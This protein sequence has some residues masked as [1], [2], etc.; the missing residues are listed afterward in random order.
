CWTPSDPPNDSPH[1][2]VL[3]LSFASRCFTAPTHVHCTK[4]CEPFEVAG[5]HFP[6][7]R[8][9]LSRRSPTTM[10]RLPSSRCST[11]LVGHTT[12]LTTNRSAAAN[13]STCWLTRCRYHIQG[14]CRGSLRASAGQ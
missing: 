12:L 11:R 3:V 8:A 5:L 13:G 10:L 4:L 14:R 7:T 1:R 2:A 9:G 6:V